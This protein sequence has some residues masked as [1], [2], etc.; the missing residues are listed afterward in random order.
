MEGVNAR[1]IEYEADEKL[2]RVLRQKTRLSTSKVFHS[3]YQLFYKRNGSGYWNGLGTIIGYDNKQVV[4][5]RGMYVCLSPGHLQLAS[6]SG[7]AENVGTSEVESDF[8]KVTE[9]AE[10]GKKDEISCN[11]NIDHTID[12]MFRVIKNGSNKSCPELEQPTENNASTLSDMLDQLELDKNDC[13]HRNSTQITCTVPSLKSRVRY[14]DPNTNIWR[15][16]LVISLKAAIMTKTMFL[17][18]LNVD[19]YNQILLIKC[20]TDSKS[21]HDTVYSS[22]T[23][24]EK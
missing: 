5:H 13:E 23:L 17:E 21:F 1:F 18:I 15:K 10:P 12:D 8:K 20:V 7:N 22:K 24:T 6:E 9:I 16:A 14:Q 2:R 11:V 4:R 3:G 19:A